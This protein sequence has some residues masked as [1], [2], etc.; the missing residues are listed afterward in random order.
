[1]SGGRR[2]VAHLGFGA[3]YGRFNRFLKAGLDGNARFSAH[4]FGGCVRYC[5]K[6]AAADPT[7]DELVGGAQREPVTFDCTTERLDPDSVQT[8]VQAFF[9]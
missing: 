3:D 8:G 1:M 4:Y 2:I 9:K 6:Q 7:S 5:R